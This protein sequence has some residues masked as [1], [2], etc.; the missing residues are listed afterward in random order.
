MYFHLNSPPDAS[1]IC[2]CKNN[3]VGLEQVLNI[4]NQDIICMA[5]YFFVRLPESQSKK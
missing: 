3:E 4:Y 2:F 5:I 1:I